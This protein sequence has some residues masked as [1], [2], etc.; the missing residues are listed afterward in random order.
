MKMLRLP[1]GEFP[2]R[3]GGVA[4]AIV[5]WFIAGMSLL[6][7]GIVAQARVD[8]RM[9]QLHVARAKAAAAGDGA[10][11]LMMVESMSVQSRETGEAPRGIYRLGD[12]E[13]KVVLVAESSLIN[14]RS[15][16]VEELGAL[17]H[18]IAGLTEEEAGRLAENVVQSRA[19]TRGA[20]TR[21]RNTAAPRMDA[22]EDLLRL[23]GMSRTLLDSIRDFIVV[24]KSAGRTDWSHATE[25][26]LG[27]LEV[28]NP[29]QADRIR[30]RR[31]ASP[32]SAQRPAMAGSYRADAIVRYGDG[33][34][35]RRRWIS[36]TSDKASSLP[37]RVIRSEPPRVL[38]EDSY[39]LG[40]STDA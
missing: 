30:A 18:F 1:A 21:N 19:V 15:A 10:I 23:P 29:E 34:W 32:A 17:F 4:L 5:V 27:V 24:S 7:A 2:G 39:L 9:A 13:V 38:Q 8:S 16:S 26:L 28:A 36:M 33:I 6:V 11:Q 20:R 37:W 40:G 12:L 22:V 35:L 31:G 14:I 25:A 3:Q